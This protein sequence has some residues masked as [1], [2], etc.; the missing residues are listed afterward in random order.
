MLALN[1]DF[2]LLLPTVLEHGAANFGTVP[3]VAHG[4]D[5]IVRTDYARSA[6]R[7]RRLASS[8]ARIG[9]KADQ[10]A[11]SL[12]WNTHRHFELFYAVSGIGAV[13][14]TANPRLPPEQIAYT[15]NFTGYRVL[16]I[17]LETLALAEALAPRLE[18]VEQY[19]VMT[20]R[21]SMPVTNLP[22]LLCYED[23]ID[24]GDDG[25]NW[26]DLDERSACAL[27]FTS[28]TTGA[29]KGALYSHRGTVLSALSTGAG[30]GWGLSADDAIIA[31]PGFFHCNGWA[32]PFFGP[33]YGA[34]LV[35]PGR[36]MDT[37]FLHRLIVDE[38]VTAG[39]G[40]PTI[41]LSILEY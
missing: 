11:G 4:Q 24:A 25:F 5:D 37:P 33:M 2:P 23:L 15:I 20:P 7:T 27:C 9:L 29:P 16:F 10:F 36:R 17:D 14:H 18:Q 30:N 1:Q 40:V 22:G 21:A 19:V 12:A 35:M 39:P 38:G 32:V 6:L 26:P 41:W 34:K 3:I 8:L 31:I 28:G 13:L